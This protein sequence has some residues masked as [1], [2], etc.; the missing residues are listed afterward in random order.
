MDWWMWLLIA[1]V[2]VFLLV[3]MMELPSIRRY[4]RLKSM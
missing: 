1:V 3:L 2:V 4:M